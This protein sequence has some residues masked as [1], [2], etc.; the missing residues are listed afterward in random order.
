MLPSSTRSRPSVIFVS[1]RRIAA[2]SAEEEL[3]LLCAATTARREATNT[4]ALQLV[5]RLDWPRLLALLR[6][7]RLVSTLG[8]R[9][10]EVAP[11]RTSERFESE[12]LETRDKDRRL[13]AFLQMIGAHVMDA[14]ADAGIRSTALKGPLLSET[15]Y[16]DPGRRPSRDI[17]LLVA[18]EQLYRAVEVVRGFGYAAPIDMAEPGGLPLLHFA[19]VHERGELPPVELHWRIHWYESRFAQERLLA[20]HDETPAWRPKPIDELTALLLFYARDGFVGLRHAVDLGT[21]WDAFAPTLTRYPLDAQIGTYRALR[22]ALLV[23]A[24]VAGGVVGLPADRLTQNT[25]AL[26]VR[27][28]IA[29]RLAEAHPHA[30]E[31]QLYAEMGLVDGLL[32]P[33]GGLR[34]FVRRQVAP[35]TRSERRTGSQ[36]REVLAGLAR[37]IKLLGRFGLTLL[38]LGCA[39]G[40]RRGGSFQD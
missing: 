11:E 5:A 18:P 31:A 9:I 2:G 33:P 30:S 25:S 14:L 12:V 27:S 10:I 28:S 21:W 19:M 37:G 4:R 13:G 7:Q 36:E 29:L 17:D 3:V 22:P 32:T 20:P 26:G 35:P 39:R 34:A 38:R 24:R 16:G 6:A 15:L 23:S 8:P 40:Q 1:Q